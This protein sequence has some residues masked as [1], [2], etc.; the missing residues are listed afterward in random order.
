MNHSII[1]SEDGS[2]TIYS[3]DFKEHFHSVHGAITESLHVFIQNGLHAIKT[4]QV[5]ILEIGFGTGLNAFLTLIDSVKNSRSVYYE[6]IE[7]FPL[8]QEFINTINYT[9]FFEDSFKNYFSQL[10]ECN[11]NEKITIV[12]NFDLKKILGDILK[13]KFSQLFDLVF[14]D[15]FSPESQPEMWTKQ[16]FEKIYL[17]MGQGG[18]L[19]TYCAKGTVKRTLKEIGFTIEL[20][21]GPPGKRHMVRAV[22]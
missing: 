2:H 15:A 17:S 3:D 22:K 6:T 9:G 11:W 12:K 20:L 13:Y 10:H 18:I 19:T 8:E 21:P 4:K 5:N 14:F 7:L 1:K 16:I